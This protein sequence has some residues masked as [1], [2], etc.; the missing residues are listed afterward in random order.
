MPACI[1]FALVVG[2]LGQ[3]GDLFESEFKRVAGV[4]D[5]GSILPGHGGFLD[6]IDALLFAMP[7]AYHV[8]RSCCFMKALSVLGSTGSIGRNTLENRRP[9]F[10]INSAVRALTAK[11][12]IALLAEQI[13][14]FQ[15]DVAVVFDEDGAGQLKAPSAWPDKDRDFIR[16]QWLPYRRCI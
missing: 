16:N 5:S 9:I 3:I 8:Q 6:R 15:P 13:V 4:K 11:S 10:P 1:L 14:Q 2:A 12:N 7:V